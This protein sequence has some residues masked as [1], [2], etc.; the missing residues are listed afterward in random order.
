MTAARATAVR[1]LIARVETAVAMALA[2]SWKPFVK[3][4]AAATRIVATRSRSAGDRLGRRAS[5]ERR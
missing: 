5:G 3:S 2:V 1:A 4:K